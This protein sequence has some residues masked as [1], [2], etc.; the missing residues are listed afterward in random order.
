[1]ARQSHPKPGFSSTLV[2]KKPRFGEE[3]K[4]TGTALE[5]SGRNRAFMK[6]YQGVLFGGNR[7]MPAGWCER[8][9]RGHD[10]ST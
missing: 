3:R 4:V 7:K 10:V 1:M 5:R 9:A 2:V 8:S 6:V